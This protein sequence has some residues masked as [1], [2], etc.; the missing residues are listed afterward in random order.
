MRYLPTFRCAIVTAALAISSVFVSAAVG[1]PKEAGS[2]PLSFIPKGVALGMAADDLQ[3][4]RPGAKEFRIPKDGEPSPPRTDLTKGDHVLIEELGAEA[5]FRGATY[6]VKNGLLVCIT[7]SKNWVLPKDWHL[8]PDQAVA[9][10]KAELRTLR[11]KT[12]AECRQR[13][14]DQYRAEAVLVPFSDSV[15]YLTPRLCWKNDHVGVAF[16]CTSEY[17]DVDILRGFVA[18]TTWLTKDDFKPPLPPAQEVESAVLSRLVQPL[19]KD[20]PR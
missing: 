6:L 5:E 7:V 19:V 4:C 13:L 16:N 15:R 20:D 17:Q 10:T 11:Q 8:K 12:L 2:E 18:V 3:K 9:A 14:G 1:G